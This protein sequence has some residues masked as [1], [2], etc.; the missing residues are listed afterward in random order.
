MASEKKKSPFSFFD[1]IALADVFGQVVTLST[2]GTMFYQTPCGAI[3]TILVCST[4]LIYGL[5]LVT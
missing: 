2:N 4:V 5:V 3:T 1:T